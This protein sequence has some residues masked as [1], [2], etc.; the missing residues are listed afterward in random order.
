[1]GEE[2]PFSIKIEPDPLRKRRCRRA[3]WGGERILLRSLHSYATQ[4]EAEKE[5]EAM[6]R[7]EA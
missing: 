6:A 3:L 7:A 4:R 2:H 1:M 5:A